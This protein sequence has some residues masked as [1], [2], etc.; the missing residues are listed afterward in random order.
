MHVMYQKPFE[1]Y[2]SYID[3]S[4]QMV[5]IHSEAD[6]KF[7]P[8]AELMHRHGIEVGVALK[9]ATTVEF[10]RPALDWIDYIL[11]FSEDLGRFGGNADMSLL[12][13]AK[14]LIG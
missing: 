11:I 3:F 6:G 4:S 12:S 1:Y 13:K 10:I 5:I 2:K 8:F 14:L 7:I 9:P